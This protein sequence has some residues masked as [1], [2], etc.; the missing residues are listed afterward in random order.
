MPTRFLALLLIACAAA[1]CGRTAPSTES[2]SSPASFDAWSDTFVR[3]WLRDAPQTATRTQYFSGAE[4]DALDR[5]LSLVGEWGTVYGASAAARR[6]ALAGRGR[7]ELQGI[8]AESMTPQQRT[9]AALLQW[10]LDNTIASAEFATHS[11][12]F[13]QFNGFQLELVNHLTQTHP[14]RQ[15]RDVE[16]YLARLDLVAPRID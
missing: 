2:S 9:S 16:N 11:Y 14:M 4:Q 13:D 12:V 10:A 5:Q 6:A 1:A 8:T 7:E 15:R 3:E